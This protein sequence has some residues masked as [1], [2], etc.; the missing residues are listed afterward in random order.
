VCGVRQPF[1]RSGA[2]LFREPQDDDALA[3]CLASFEIKASV[4]DGEPK[5]EAFQ[6]DTLW[7]PAGDPAP[8]Q[9]DDATL[10]DFAGASN[11][12]ISAGAR[13]DPKRADVAWVMYRVTWTCPQA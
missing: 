2:V 4:H 3:V 11:V 6:N 1:A 7:L 10:T 8:R 5:A 9:F 12:R 13:G